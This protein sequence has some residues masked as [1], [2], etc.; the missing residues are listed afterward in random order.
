MFYRDVYWRFDF[1]KKQL[2]WPFN[3]LFKPFYYLDWYA[4]D[5]FCEVI[6][7]PSET[8][9]LHLP[10]KRADMTFKP[11]PPGFEANVTPRP[12]FETK[13][14]KPL[15]LLYVGGI[16]PTV[17]NISDLLQIVAG[18]K[19]LQLTICC[20][21]PEWQKYGY[22][23]Q[24]LMSDNIQLAHVHSAELA[25]YYHESDAFLML[26]GY[27][28][29]MDFAMPV[30]FSEAIG[31]AVPIV[32]LNQKEV[33]DYIISTD[34]GWVLDEISELDQLLTEIAANRSML[35]AKYDHLMSHRKECSWNARAEYIDQ[36]L[37]SGK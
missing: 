7:L 14:S 11:L 9:N 2:A 30:K 34:I 21:L 25:R 32:S 29:Y 36:H 19:N 31:Y 3:I 23:Y 10:R 27:S 33:A 17:Y 6:F 4:Y 15:K 12:P 5:K 1:F 37:A 20:R 16:E 26:M 22:L 28:E 24:S 8:M 18:R 35:I 13:T